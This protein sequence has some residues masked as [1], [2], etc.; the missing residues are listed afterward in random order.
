MTPKARLLP[1]HKGV[2]MGT[3]Q[4]KP[5]EDDLLSEPEQT[6]VIL[7][8]ITEGVF[9]VDRDWCVTSFNRAASRSPVSPARTRSAAAAG[10]SSRPASASRIAP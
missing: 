10:R 4:D 5:R 8:S 9:T 2:G 7:D 3:K 1:D 6:R